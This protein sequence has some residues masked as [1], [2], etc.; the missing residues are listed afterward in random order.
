MGEP[1]SFTIK[2]TS[3]PARELIL[4]G[5]ALPYQPFELEGSMRAEFTWYPGNAVATTQM[6]GAQ[7]KPTVIKGRW[8]DRFIR[9]TTDA[10]VPVTNTGLALF[11]GLSVA[12]VFQLSQAVE[13]IRLAGQEVEVTWDSHV[14]IGILLRFR[15]SW[16]RREDLD[17][18]MEFQWTSRGEK[19]SPVTL[20]A[21]P[22]TLNL[23]AQFADEVEVLRVAM[24]PPIFS[25]V[26]EF[27]S[28][29]ES[30]FEEIDDASLAVENAVRAGL[31]LALT[32]V[33]VAERGLA[34]AESMR[35]A[36]SN[37]VAA[38]E[39]FPP[40]QLIKRPPDDDA[41]GVSLGDVLV[42]D[43]WSRA[44]KQAA[45]ALQ[46]TASAEADSLKTIARQESLLAV[47]VAKQPLDLRDVSVKYYGTQEEW[48]RILIYNALESSRLEAGQTVLVP[49]IT[50]SE[51]AA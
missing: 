4:R 50:F 32:P 39:Q 24:E 36:A 15:Q 49:R 7:E 43:Q 16:Q 20:P 35:V 17:W 42:A 41:S 40:L 10:G 30:A 29:I 21:S 25:V 38:V 31:A 2:T 12:D 33:E 27:T 11:N 28:T 14:R 9:H 22:E 51:S 13:E 48:R 5:R 37:I 18:E 19:Q 47:F 44:I 6:L 8:K 3:A 46:A 1:T 23:S 26:E 45:R 34:A